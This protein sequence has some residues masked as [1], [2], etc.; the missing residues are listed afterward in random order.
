MCSVREICDDI[1]GDVRL[2][3]KLVVS[4]L[5][6]PYPLLQKQTYAVPLFGQLYGGV[7][8]FCAS[9]NEL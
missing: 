9:I 5:T 7:D 6:P 8:V 2:E 4:A 1:T 3:R